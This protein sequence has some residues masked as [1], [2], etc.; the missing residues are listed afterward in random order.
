MGAGVP[1]LRMQIVPQHGNRVSVYSEDS[2][3]LNLPSRYQRLTS[4]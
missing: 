2:S 4:E 3:S 1:V